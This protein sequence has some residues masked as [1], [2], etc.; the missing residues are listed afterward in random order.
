MV[1]ENL[2]VN[3]PDGLPA[4]PDGVASLSFPQSES[5]FRAAIDV[6][7][8]RWPA[9]ILYGV[10]AVCATYAVVVFVWY[11]VVGP[12]SSLVPVVVISVVLCVAS[13]FGIKRFNRWVVMRRLIKSKQ[14]DVLGSIC[15]IT[16]KDRVLTLMVDPVGVSMTLPVSRMERVDET[17]SHV[18][19]WTTRVNV[20]PIPRQSVPKTDLDAFLSALFTP[21][22]TADGDSPDR[23]PT[24]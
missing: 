6:Q 11:F 19:L 24:G 7:S 17:M 21:L 18:F 3:L 23:T 8:A 15:T 14:R 22:R 20:I 9:R 1:C 5:D 2:I 13:Y 16:I 12:I 10:F 4:S